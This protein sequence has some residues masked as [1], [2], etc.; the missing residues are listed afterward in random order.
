MPTTA[1]RVFHVMAILSGLLCVATLARWATFDMNAET[2][3]F[4]YDTGHVGSLQTQNNVDLTL[5]R[6]TTFGM[7]SRHWRRWNDWGLTLPFWLVA[8][9]FGIFAGMCMHISRR[10]IESRVGLCA[11]C[12]YDLRATPDRCP[13][14]GS[15]QKMSATC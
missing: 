6:G 14:C 1:T 4:T 15:N 3:H 2:W 10:A 7:Q 8:V 12:R 9:V 11:V 5:S 13:E